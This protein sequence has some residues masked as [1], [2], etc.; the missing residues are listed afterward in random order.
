MKNSIARLFFALLSGTLVTTSPL[1]AAPRG[2]VQ[3]V[4]FP[5]WNAASVNNLA[6]A[7]NQASPA[8]FEL[9]QA[10]FFGGDARWNN[11]LAFLRSVN[12]GVR[13][14]GT[15]FL[16]FHTDQAGYS[17][18]RR[19]ANLNTFLITPRSELGGKTPI[20]R[21]ANLVL[22]PQLEDHYDDATWRSHVKGILDKL[23]EAQVLRSG[24]LSLRR[25]VDGQGSS[26]SSYTYTRGAN[27][28]T[29]SVRIERHGVRTVPSS[30]NWSND[31]DFVFKD[32]TVG[33]VR[34]TS[35]SMVDST[36]SGFARMSLPDFSSSARRVSIPT[37]LWRPAYNIWRREVSNGQVRWVRDS[38]L[39]AAWDRS[40]AGTTFDEREKRVLVEFLNALK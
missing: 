36:N 34:E 24:K 10:P 37:T 5:N 14:V 15:M 23:D 21:F 19:A 6:S 17:L 29:F 38:R 12:P 26:L 11:T 33:G 30:G 7:V 39:A 8:E 2:G 25:S 35:A 16:S 20:V 3:A 22:S 27:R 31:G 13:I 4:V 28:Y 32:M 40:D 18:P 1:R 9:S